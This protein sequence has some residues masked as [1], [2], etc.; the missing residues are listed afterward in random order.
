MTKSENRDVSIIQQSTNKKESELGVIVKAKALVKHTYVITSNP[1]HYPKKMR[2]TLANRLQE[3]AT[4]VFEC[5]LEANEL[6]LTDASQK[7]DRLKLQARALTLCKEIL[8]LIELSLDMG[9]INMQNS[10]YWTGL[11]LNVK[12]MT[13]AW[14]KKDRQR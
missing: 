1:N 9:Y 13:A 10:E 11:V 7:T 12:Y 14:L 2:F 8:F 5:L 6:S 4:E 3:K